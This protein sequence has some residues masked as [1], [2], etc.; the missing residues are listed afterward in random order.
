MNTVTKS[1]R[2]VNR[3]SVVASL[4]LVAMVVATAVYIGWPRVASAIGIKPS[5]PPPAYAAGQQVDVP[6]AW[7]SESDKTLL[8]FA[9]ASCVACQKAQ[10]FLKK[11][12]G[13]LNGRAV[14][15]MAHPAGADA[16]DLAFAQALGITE[17]HLVIVKPGLKVRST[18]TI[19][20]VNRNGTVLEAWE[21]AGPPEKQAS[22]VK[23]IDAALR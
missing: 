4:S 19:V 9:R 17:N 8:I 20:V 5:A 15:V 1:D 6:V 3:L 16:D 21:G 10:P 7:Y 22:I 13:R 18:P 23:A 11:L 14:A 12:V 2:A